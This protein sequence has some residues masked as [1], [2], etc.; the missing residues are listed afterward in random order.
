MLCEWWDQ[1]GVG[2]C[3]AL[4]VVVKDR[5]IVVANKALSGAAVPPF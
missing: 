1:G 4:H 3:C 5:Y 2:V